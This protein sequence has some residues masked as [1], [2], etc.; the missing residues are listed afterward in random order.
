MHTTA[1]KTTQPA[2]AVKATAD[3]T[4]FFRKAGEESF[5]GAAKQSSFFNAPVQAKLNISQPGDPL[6]KEAD[7]TADK[8]MRMPD[9]VV[10]SSTSEKKEDE[11][12]RKEGEQEEEMVQAKLMVNNSG[13]LVMRSE[14]KEDDKQET[15]QPKLY[16]TGIMRQE[17]EEEEA[18]QRKEE[19]QEET[20]Q[21]SVDITPCCS[22]GILQRKERGPPSAN[23]S[24]SFTSQL[25]SSKGQGAPLNHSVLHTMQNKFGA[26]F[27]SVRI[28]NNDSSA[29]LSRSINAQAFT[30]GNDIYFNHGKYNPHTSSG[31]NLL[32]HEL[33]HTIQQGAS[34][35][36]VK[37]SK[38]TNTP[39]PVKGSNALLPVTASQNKAEQPVVPQ[40]AVLSQLESPL[41]DDQPANPNKAVL[42]VNATSD[43]IAAP[44]GGNFDKGAKSLPEE[45][46][47]QTIKAKQTAGDDK[48]EVVGDTLKKGIVK[49]AGREKADKATLINDQINS[50]EDSVIK[51]HVVNQAAIVNQ[52]Y[53]VTELKL[54]KTSSTRKQEI[55]NLFR[56]AHA[57]IDAFFIGNL[58]T[59]SATIQA[60]QVNIAA[61]INGALASVQSFINAMSAMAITLVTTAIGF[62]STLIATTLTAIAGTISNVTGKVASLVNSVSL[63]DLPGVETARNFIT[64]SI[65]SVSGLITGALSAVQMLILSALATSLQFL[66]GLVQSITGAIN[67]ILS[68]IA[69][70]FNGII[71]GI[72]AGLQSILQTVTGSLQNLLN[73][74]IHPTLTGVEEMVL[75][76]VDTFHQKALQDAKENREQALEALAA[77]VNQQSQTAEAKNSDKPMTEAE[78]I[79]EIESIGKYAVDR[80]K[81]ISAKLI[82]DLSLLISLLANQ[83]VIFIALVMA[84]IIGGIAMII[85]KVME[86]I[87]YITQYIAELTAKVIGEFMNFVNKII[88]S[89]TDFMTSVSE[90]ITNPFSTVKEYAEK[91]WETI[92]SFVSNVVNNFIKEIFNINSQQGPSVQSYTSQEAQEFKPAY[93]PGTIIEEIVKVIVEAFGTIFLAI[94]LGILTAIA[95]VLQYIIP[96]I[97][98]GIAAILL[99]YLIWRLIGGTTPIP[100]PKP[101][102]KPKPSPSMRHKTK[103]NAP[104]GSPKTRN[105][106][107]VGEKVK[108]TGN[109]IGNWTATGG[110]P[111]QLIGSKR[112]IWTAP[113]RADTVTVTFSVGTKSVS[114]NME[115]IEPSHYTAIKLAEY[116]YPAGTQGAGMILDFSFHPKT[117][118]FG[119]VQQ[120][121]VSGPATNITGYYLLHGMPHHHN[122]G[123]KFFNMSEDNKF[124]S[125]HDQAHQRNYPQPWDTG[126]FDWIIPNHFKLK[127]ES[128]NGKKYH[129]ATQSFRMAD[130][131][132]KTTITKEGES[133]ERTP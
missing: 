50:A 48:G 133:V 78:M 62:V 37:N 96:A 128:G 29:Q 7:A 26:D 17:A 60:A 19:E 4:S 53:F 91:A 124:E 72:A 132:G 103:F 6:E 95:F 125:A 94:V 118:S 13:S 40:N 70:I 65:S 52:D 34:T 43:P 108:F 8:V 121:E 36:T 16:A 83:S 9:S 131:S 1:E 22:T 45:Q 38:K 10:P 77:M 119:N 82:E 11:L 99:I 64:S 84:A 24:S 69:S 79:T 27:G 63:P 113:P 112:F 18:I 129:D 130:A 30:H 20:V 47:A 93:D 115:V 86:L 111:L 105:K 71:S 90:F 39:Q 104:D 92:K 76:T 58:Q 88:E 127:S 51:S 32:A 25:Q 117:V 54:N 59:L 101:K 41:K 106:V 61:Q 85:S 23:N 15:I 122:S 31:G 21:R 74:T 55:R 12:Q 28:H 87:N 42:A 110:V 57:N 68:T 97:M 44:V 33:T 49:Q 35:Q 81:Q 123:N 46:D 2:K 56:S 14:E 67:T 80:N 116:I 5:F 98:I 66:T 100:K 3:K 89:I 75:G 109:M 73:G 120:K 126:G 114:E 107:G 102:P